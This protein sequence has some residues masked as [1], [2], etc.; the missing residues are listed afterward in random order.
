VDDVLPD[1]DRDNQPELADNCPLHANAD[2]TDG[3]NDRRGN[4][5]D[6]D[7]DNDGTVTLADV[8]R[9]RGCEGADLSVGRG[10]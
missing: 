2:Q 1:S 3:D 7:L 8:R 9:T 5:C 10:A 6:F 4:L